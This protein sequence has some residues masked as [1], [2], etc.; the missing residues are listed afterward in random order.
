MKGTRS[1]GILATGSYTPERVLTNFDLEKMVETSDEWIVS[2]TGIRERRICGPEQASSDLALEA[3]KKA[4]A[5]ANISPEQLDMIIVAT[6][7]PD[8]MFPSTACILQEKLGAKKAAALDVSAACTGFLYGIATGSQFIANGLYRYIL[9]VGVETL[10]KITNYKDRN[11]CVLFGDGA[12]AAV[13]GPVKDGLGFQAFELGADGSGG[14]L[15]SQPAGGSRI[16]ASA[17]SI[18]NNLHYISMAGGEVFKFA[19]RVMNSATEAVLEKSGASKEDIDLLVPH[20]A[21][22][23]I[24][25]SA[26]Q[27]FGLS[28]DKVAI[29]LDRYGNM[30]SAS[31]PV[32][33]DE[34]IQ[35]GRLKE[36]DN[37]ILVGFGGGLTWGATLLKW[38]TQEAEGGE[39]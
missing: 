31:I 16:P 36:G 26:I 23:R 32:A 17:E 24:I 13:L 30:S 2:R 12:G 29:N 4:L 8:T 19:V 7:T 20:Q 25:D 33:L 35:E 10:S 14:A 21:N 28:E 11:T 15:L 22:K 37:V 38:S 6:V 5:K 9:V 27:R 34:A 18:E 1:V 39:K 3:A